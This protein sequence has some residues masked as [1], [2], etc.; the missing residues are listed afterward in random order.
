MNLDM[1][2]IQDAQIVATI[3]LC[4]DICNAK[5]YS[6]RVDILAHSDIAPE[7]KLD[8]G[9]LFPWQKLFVAG[10]GLWVEPER[11]S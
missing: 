6:S 11:I 2:R 10:I 9:E 7:R 3:K 4:K 5:K 8:P 1:Y